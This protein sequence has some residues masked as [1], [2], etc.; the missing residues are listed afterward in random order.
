VEQIK[1]LPQTVMLPLTEANVD[2][3]EVSNIEWKNDYL[4]KQH[5][6]ELELPVKIARTVTDTNREI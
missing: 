1:A 5:N 4:S 6:I 2:D 3:E